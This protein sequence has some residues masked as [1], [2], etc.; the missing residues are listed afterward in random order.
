MYAPT[1][2]QTSFH[3]AVGSA[4]PPRNLL[5]TGSWTRVQVVLA[6]GAV[7]VASLWA[8]P[9]RDMPTSTLTQDVQAF[10]QRVAAGSATEADAAAP[11]R[12]ARRYLGSLSPEQ[13][14][15]ISQQVRAEQQA[16]LTAAGNDAFVMR[17][18]ALYE[19]ALQQRVAVARVPMAGGADAQ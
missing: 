12:L 9:Q 5:T 1:S 4:V 7:A 6:L 13:R 2:T 8:D 14:Q 15:R 11:E 17:R 18:L 19:E 16:G 10:Q 3:V